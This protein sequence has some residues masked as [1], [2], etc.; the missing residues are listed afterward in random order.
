MGTMNDHLHG[1]TEPFDWAFASRPLTAG[2]SGDACALFPFV[3]G[4]LIAVIDGLGHG[5]EAAKAAA[6]AIAVLRAHADESLVVL[7]ERCHAALHA[8][9]GAVMSLV[10]VRGQ[11]AAL[12]WLGVG[13]V[14]CVLLRASGAH[15]KA[16]TYLPLTGGIVGYK[17]PELRANSLCLL[18]G[19]TLVLATDGIDVGFLDRVGLSSPPQA[20]ADAILAKC[21]RVDDD[22]LVLI[23]R[24]RQETPSSREAPS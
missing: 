19:D 22:A 3:G 20:L 13:N 12:T 14:E 5:P 18:P 23:A 6:V 10:S 1:S 24:Y 17:L 15:E 4:V 21:A 2:E 7:M 16:R 8:T 9:R 11:D